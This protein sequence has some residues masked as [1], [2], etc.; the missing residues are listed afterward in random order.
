MFV[1]IYYNSYN[2]QSLNQFLESSRVII[3]LNAFYCRYGSYWLN[4]IIQ[5]KNNRSP[6]VFYFRFKLLRFE[7]LF[8]FATLIPLSGVGTTCFHHVVIKTRPLF[9][10]PAA[11]RQAS[12]KLWVLTTANAA[13][14]N[15]LTCLPKHG[16]ARNSKF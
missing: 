7:P 1:K 5:F 3:T 12:L 10:R 11:C 14:T 15:S 2:E 6:C 4:K 9:L 8:I 13:G 16:G